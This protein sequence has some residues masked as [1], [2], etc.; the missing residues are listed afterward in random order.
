MGSTSA[1]GLSPAK[2]LAGK[3]SEE[4]LDL[5]YATGAGRS[6]LPHHQKRPEAAAYFSSQNRAGR[7]SYPGLLSGIGDVA[8][9]G[10]VDE[11]QRT[12]QLCATVGGGDRHD[13]V[14]GRGAA[15]SFRPGAGPTAA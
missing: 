9:L 5:V 7:G 3:G 13:Q 14:D 12:G 8:N 4:V 6:G 10:N 2:Q 15:R 11:R 1:G